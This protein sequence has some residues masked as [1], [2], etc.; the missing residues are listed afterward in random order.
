MSCAIL[1]EGASRPAVAR[2]NIYFDEF[3]DADPISARICFHCADAPCLEACPV[4][5]IYR[6]PR[7]GAVII[8]EDTCVGCMRCA[9]E[10][11]W[12]VPK[13]HP[14]RRKAIKCDLCSDRPEGP[15][16]VSVCPL[17]G[18]A[19]TYTPTRARQ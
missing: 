7:T 16:C 9:Q 15:Y 5:A 14:D 6:H 1:K 4:E 18:K 2:L 11:P 17:S 12:D 19:L 10:C 13:R 3:A 8:D